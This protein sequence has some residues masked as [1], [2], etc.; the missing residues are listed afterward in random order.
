M[1]DFLRK[2][3]LKVFIHQYFGGTHR[4]L[5]DK[6]VR[7][8]EKDGTE[9][10]YLKK[11][12][13]KIRPIP[14]EA[15]VSGMKGKVYADLIEPDKGIY[16]PAKYGNPSGQLQLVSKEMDTWRILQQTKANITYPKKQSWLE[17]YMPLVVLIVTGGILGFITLF[18]MNGLGV[19]SGSV[20]SATGHM[21]NT[22]KMILDFWSKTPPL[23]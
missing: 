5:E 21:E 4:L 17:K 9:Y 6:A 15:M 13:I 23:H 16:F 7:V 19:V 18:V 12:K 3:P 20:A 8:K 1:F 11:Q 22:M 2:A 10:H 14:F